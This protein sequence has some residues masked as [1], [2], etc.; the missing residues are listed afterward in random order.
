MS[1]PSRGK[2]REIDPCPSKKIAFVDL[3]PGLEGFTGFVAGAS[4]PAN[5]VN[6]FKPVPV[7]AVGLFAGGNTHS[8]HSKQ[9]QRTL[10]VPQGD[11]GLAL[12]GQFNRAPCLGVGEIGDPAF[13]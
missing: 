11:V 4:A 1:D 8:V 2:I 12:N 6:P 5:P 3:V 7:R 9:P 10:S 13:E